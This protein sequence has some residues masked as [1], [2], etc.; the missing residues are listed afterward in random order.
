M[1]IHS[2]TFW[3]SPTMDDPDAP[4]SD[5]GDGEERT[6]KETAEGANLVAS[7]S[8]RNPAGPDGHPQFVGV[9]NDVHL[10][11]LDLD[12]PARLVPSSSPGCSHLFI[13]VP[14]SWDQYERLLDLLSD[15]GIIEAGYAEASIARGMTMLRTSPTKPPEQKERSATRRAHRDATEGVLQ[16]MRAERRDAQAVVAPE[17]DDRGPRQ[18]DADIQIAFLDGFA[19]GAEV[20]EAVARHG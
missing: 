9:A 10:P 5:E 15:M 16:R 7:W 20:G 1:T 12:V 4:A 6:R 8:A 18:R 19:Q 2:R 3:H 13:D 17:P 14:V 11:C